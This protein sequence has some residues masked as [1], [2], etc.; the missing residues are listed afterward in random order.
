[1]T[2]SGEVRKVLILEHCSKLIFVYLSCNKFVT[3]E[4]SKENS[5]LGRRMPYD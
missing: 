2:N 4:T 1:M 3:I 5:L